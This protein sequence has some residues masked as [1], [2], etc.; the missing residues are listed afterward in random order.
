MILISELIDNYKEQ[1]KLYYEIER[2][3]YCV[4]KCN[5]TVESVIKGLHESKKI[6]DEISVFDEKR[7][8]IEK[9]CIDRYKM[10]RFEIENLPDVINTDLQIELIEEIEKLRSVIKS[11]LECKEDEKLLMEEKFIMAKKKI[12]ETVKGAD[13]V[14][15]YKKKSY[16]S[17][18]IDKILK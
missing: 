2:V 18:F 7:V 3:A 11:V 16:D 5:R 15:G 6:I 14:R 8:N 10:K 13:V 17:V 4:Q 1:I 12:N 9:K